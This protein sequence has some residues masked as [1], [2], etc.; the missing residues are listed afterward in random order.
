MKAKFAALLFC[1]LPILFVA[2]LRGQ[3]SSPTP[4]PA[5][6]PSNASGATSPAELPAVLPQASPSPTAAI[7]PPSLIPPNLLPPPE[8][9]PKVPAAPELQMLNDFFKQT[10]LGKVADEKRLHLELARLET[11]I[12][13]DQT[14]HALRAAADTAPTDLERRHRLKTYYEAY[15]GKLRALA[16]APDLQGYI[17]AQKASHQMTLLQ[18]HVRHQTDEAAAAALAKEAAQAS[19]V[20]PAKPLPTPVQAR[21][22]QKVH[23]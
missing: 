7:E 21:A 3:S 9:L 13:N 12:R 19:V 16:T 17:V 14:L 1:A 20:A 23:Q 5:P 2:A 4:T 11:R 15:Y 22:G 18:P 8:A 6:V 10:S